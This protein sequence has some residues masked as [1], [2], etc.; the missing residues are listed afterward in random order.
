[1]NATPDMLATSFKML[2]ALALVLG[3]LGI[4]FYFTKRVMRKDIGSSVGEMIRVLASQYIGLKKKHLP[5]R[6]SRGHTGRRYQR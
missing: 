3:G 2:A 6:N 1:M 4:F 5:D